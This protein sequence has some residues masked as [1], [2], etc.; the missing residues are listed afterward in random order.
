MG[1]PDWTPGYKCG[2]GDAM[3]LRARLK[4]LERGV[5]FDRDCCPACPPRAVVRYHQDGHD[6]EPVLAGGQ[7]PPALCRHCGRPARVLPLV[8]IYDP[9]FYGNAERLEELLTDRTGPARRR[10]P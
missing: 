8:V 4:K 2:G 7:K 1:T 10:E 3:R 9:S 5:A 6:G